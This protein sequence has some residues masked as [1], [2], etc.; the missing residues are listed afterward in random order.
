MNLNSGLELE[1]F[2]GSEDNRANLALCEG[3]GGGVPCL[4]TYAGTVELLALNSLTFL[5]RYLYK[6]HYGLCLFCSCF[7]R[8]RAEQLPPD[9]FLKRNVGKI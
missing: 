9:D 1:L 7:H 2:W 6:F 8:L 4:F 5:S 3:G